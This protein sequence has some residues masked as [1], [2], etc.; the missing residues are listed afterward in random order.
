MPESSI[1]E[2]A[3]LVISKEMAGVDTSYYTDIFKD[4]DELGSAEEFAS[5]DDFEKAKYIIANYT[6]LVHERLGQ[7]LV[8]DINYNQVKRWA[9]E[10]QSLVRH[11][12]S[13]HF[14]DFNIIAF[15]KWVQPKTEMIEMGFYTPSNRANKNIFH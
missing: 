4:L 11:L 3:P 12:F 13:L 1:P 10:N 5:E 7:K 8:R 14:K 9:T 15:N 2:K 6:Y